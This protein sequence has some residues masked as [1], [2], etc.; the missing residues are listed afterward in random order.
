MIVTFY[1]YKGGV[2]RSMALM[3]VAEILAEAGYKVLICDFDL[4]APGLERY[5]CNSQREALSLEAQEGVIDLLTDYKDSLATPSAAPEAPLPELRSPL[6]ASVP[7]LRERAG[8]GWLRLLTAGKRNDPDRPYAR[9]VQNFDWTDFYE[10]WAGGSY[11][12]F[13]RKSVDRVADPTGPPDRADI[14]LIDSRTGVTEHG[15]VCTHHLADLVVLL[16]AANDLNTV[17]TGWMAE[18]LA[19]PELTMLRSGRP[20]RLLPISARIEQ[21]AE[22]EELV[23]FRHRFAELFQARLSGL[24]SHTFFDKTEIPYVPFYSFVERVVARESPERRHRELYSAY[25]QLSYA[26]VREGMDMGLLEAPVVAAWLPAS[27][28][29]PDVPGVFPFPRIL[30]AHEN[31]LRSEGKEGEMAMLAERDLRNQ[32]LSRR[33]LRRA[34][35]HGANLERANLN[36]CDLTEAILDGARLDRA[37]LENA[38]LRGASFRGAS[39]KFADLTGADLTDCDL[40]GAVLGQAVL[41]DADLRSVLG[42]TRQ[43]ID[44]ADINQNTRLPY[45]LSQE[46]VTP[47][48]GAPVTIRYRAFICNNHSDE[49]VAASIQQALA[50]FGRPWFGRRLRVFRPSTGLSGDLQ[51]EV[52]LQRLLESEFLILLASPSA[53]ASSWVNHELRQWLE[54]KEARDIILIRVAGEV[55]WDSAAGDFSETSTAVP[56]ELR[57]IF[58]EQPLL[59]D[60]SWAQSQDQLNPAYPLFQDTIATISARIT[61]VDK[62]QIIG[63]ELRK[64]R[65]SRRT[66]VAAVALLVIL[67]ALSAFSLALAQRRHADALVS[68]Q[69][70]ELEAQATQEA[71]SRLSIALAQNEALQRA[72]TAVGGKKKK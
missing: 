39:L 72:L 21:S 2:G 48:G 55:L 23:K 36:E 71:Q 66:L 16:S 65:Q 60:L 3:N 29:N 20:L 9:R 4:E 61:H 5:A 69:K 28:M 35:L 51:S 1:S 50:R 19:R 30:I 67:L 54:R 31:W 15:G 59:I 32:D 49:A 40:S 18:R 42:L 68:L 13:F 10:R 34:D 47:A 27:E 11:I 7:L 38:K 8:K 26:I 56:R 14:V 33:V 43:Q 53:A 57:G 37:I 24:E 6:A 41:H 52:L 58:A 44:A 46:T 64:Y 22:K 62:S 63:A 45:R 12:E 25:L 17:G 70:A